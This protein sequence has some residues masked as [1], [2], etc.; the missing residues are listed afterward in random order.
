MPN[1]HPQ[2]VH[3]PIA[4]GIFLLLLAAAWSLLNK[5]S[6]RTAALWVLP[7]TALGALGAATTGLIFEEFFPHPHEGEAFQLMELHE[8]L[9]LVT[10]AAFVSFTALIWIFKNKVSR[11]FRWACL[12]AALG[13]AGLVIFTGYLG[14]ELGHTHGLAMPEEA[15]KSETPPSPKGTPPEGA[16]EPHGDSHDHDHHHDH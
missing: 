15:K 11:I 12:L 7:L 2:I 4:G 13:L 14:G 16:Q 5:E 8:T 6:A 1:L 10:A 9:G 3:F